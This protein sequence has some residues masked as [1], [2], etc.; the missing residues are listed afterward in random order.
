MY[1]YIVTPGFQPLHRI[2]QIAREFSFETKKE[3]RSFDTR[4]KSRQK[5]LDLMI[6]HAISLYAD[7]QAITGNGLPA[8]AEFE[9]S[10][11]DSEP[12]PALLTNSEANERRSLEKLRHYR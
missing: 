12:K 7:L 5:L 1:S 8:I 9:S 3:K 4:I 10:G 2:V 6:D 11:G